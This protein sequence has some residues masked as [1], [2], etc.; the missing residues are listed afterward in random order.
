MDQRFLHASPSGVRGLALYLVGGY[1]GA[2]RAYRADLRDA[3]ARDRD[4]FDPAWAAFVEEEL[5][6][7]KTIARRRLE[8][9]EAPMSNLLTLGEIA[10]VERDPD[11]ALAHFGQVLRQERDQFDALLLTSVAHVRRGAYDRAID[12][13]THALREGRAETRITSFLGALDV[14]GELSSLAAGQRPW[15]LLAQYHRYLRTV[16]PSQSG[17]TIRYATKALAVG[18]RPADAYTA[19]GAIYRHEDKPE[20]ALRAFLQAIEVDPRH[21]EAYRQAGLIYADR[22]DLAN[23]YRMAKAA[24]DSAPDDSYYADGLFEIATR[25]LGDY[26]E[27][28]V[29]GQRAI[30]RE[31]GNGGNWNRLGGV[32]RF[33][34]DD[35]H[36][37]Q[38]LQRATEMTPT[39]PAFHEDLGDALLQM[40]R[41][42]EAREVFERAVTIAPNGARAH[43]GLAFAFQGQRRYP[44]ALKEY[45]KV[46]EVGARLNADQLQALCEL[47]FSTSAFERARECLKRVLALE[48]GHIAAGRWLDRVQES[49]SASPGSRP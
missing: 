31:P 22:G 29:I 46:L 14:I 28:L 8:A 19:I 20:S 23:E 35:D 36:A 34:G 32:Y 38:H 9:G 21:A 49:L 16:D 11:L 13:L 40:D 37:I 41:M 27:A 26:Q 44:E 42:A 17:V 5:Q 39:N 48:P 24:F 10:L 3:V 45:E 30:E 43:L 1:S 18:D 7:A 12:A 2:A 4:R 25:K 6:T 15:C 33:L 47:Y